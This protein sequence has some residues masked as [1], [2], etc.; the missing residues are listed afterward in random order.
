M[1]LKL[2]NRPKLAQILGYVSRKET[3]SAQDFTTRTL[4]RLT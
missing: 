1:N 2:S 4:R 3:S